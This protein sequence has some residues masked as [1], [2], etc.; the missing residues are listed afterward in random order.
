MQKQLLTE[1]HGETSGIEQ[2]EGKEAHTLAVAV[3]TKSSSLLSTFLKPNSV[4]LT[5]PSNIKSAVVSIPGEPTIIPTSEQCNV[6]STSGQ[7]STNAENSPLL[8]TT[9]T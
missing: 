1:Q 9:V 5:S 4:L 3:A 7:S 2:H 6:F 8:K